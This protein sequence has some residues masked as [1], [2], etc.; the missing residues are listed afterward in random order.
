MNLFANEI[1]RSQR[2]GALA[3]GYG[4]VPDYLTELKDNIS[5]VREIASRYC[6]LTV[7]NKNLRVMF[8]SYFAKLLAN[9]NKQLPGYIEGLKQGQCIEAFRISSGQYRDDEFWLALSGGIFSLRRQ[10]PSGRMKAS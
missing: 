7:K 1:E 5:D 6:S 2:V 9:V 4:D 8:A 3:A 10:S